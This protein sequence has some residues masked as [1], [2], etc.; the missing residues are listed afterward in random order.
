MMPDLGKY[1]LW[2]LSAYG[3]SIALLA[4]ITVLSILQ[5]RR[6][7]RALQ[8]MEAGRKT[9]QGESARSATPGTVKE[10]ANG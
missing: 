8:A 10:A 5:S 2:V 4:T 3:V 9:G 6:T 1:A 7:R